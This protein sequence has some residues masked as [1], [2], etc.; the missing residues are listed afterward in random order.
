MFE[1]TGDRVAAII[2]SK[3]PACLRA[4]VSWKSREHAQH[5]PQVSAPASS[6][7]DITSDWT[8][9]VAEQPGQE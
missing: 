6:L 9:L 3:S 2:C 1:T 4:T 8:P 5:T 7:G